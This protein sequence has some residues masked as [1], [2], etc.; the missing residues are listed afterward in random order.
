MVFT[1][2]AS[3]A[4]TPAI[5]LPSAFSPE[6]LP[7][8]IQFVGRRVSEPVLCR[9]AQAYEQATNGYARHPNVDTL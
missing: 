7:Y 3:L 6:G 4:G 9:I 2:P 8:S 5:C 1:L